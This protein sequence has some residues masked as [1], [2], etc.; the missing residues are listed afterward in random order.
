MR[1]VRESAPALGRP[2]QTAGGKATR[3][4]KLGCL[5]RAIA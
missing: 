3:G 4:W 1:P 2:Q 5:E